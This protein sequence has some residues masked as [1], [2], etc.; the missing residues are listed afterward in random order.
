MVEYMMHGHAFQCRLS[1]LN[2]Q[3]F[4]T[5]SACLGPFSSLTYL[6][7]SDNMGGLDPSGQR[8]GEGVAAIAMNLSHSL[9]MRVLK[10]ARNFLVDEDISA[11]AAAL[12]NMPQFQDLD[13]SGNLCHCSGAKSLNLAFISHSVL[14]QPG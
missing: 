8:N 12:H 3:C 1:N 4:R 13:L 11:I 2:S 10:L 5:I 7:L 6:D 14:A 9:H